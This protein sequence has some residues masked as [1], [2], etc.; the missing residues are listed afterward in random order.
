LL[1]K[2]SFEYKG[3]NFTIN[4]NI[5]PLNVT[6]LIDYLK[7]DFS[8]VKQRINTI[9]INTGL[10]IVIVLEDIDTMLE[11]DPLYDQLLTT[12]F[13]GIGAIDGSYILATTN[14]PDKISL[15]LLRQNRFSKVIS[16]E[17]IKDIEEVKHYLDIHLQ[18][19]QEE[20]GKD[21]YAHILSIYPEKFI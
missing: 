19:I 8:T 13:E 10:P 2:K 14:H 15:R 17:L 5:V 4:A 1:N 18:D 3:K 7:E 11:R 21:H 9:R 12:F 6:H 20:I 16:Y